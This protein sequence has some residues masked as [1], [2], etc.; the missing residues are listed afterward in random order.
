L[1]FRLALFVA[2]EATVLELE[3]DGAAGAFAFVCFV[4]KTISA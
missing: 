4:V 2:F 3:R 1:T